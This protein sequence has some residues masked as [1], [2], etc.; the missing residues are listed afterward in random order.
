MSDQT[1]DKITVSYDDLASR[2]VEQRLKE[3]DALAR[4]RT[5]AAMDE[6]MV[7][8]PESRGPGTLE[9]LW[10]NSIFALALFGFIGGLLAWGCGTLLEFKVDLRADSAEKLKGVERLITQTEKGN[11]T[12]EQGRSTIDMA[13]DNGRAENPH[14]GL[15]VIRPDAVFRRQALDRITVLER[16]KLITPAKAKEMTD[17]QL[18]EGRRD[19]PDFAVMTD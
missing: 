5:Y 2:K 15:M 14:F 4:N 13:I 12:P 18:L 11:L 3:Q 10:R 8:T 6:T 17:Q 9:G 7:A 1:P 19:N 16:S